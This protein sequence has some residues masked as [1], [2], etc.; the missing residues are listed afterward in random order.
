M[1][2][3]S[4]RIRLLIAWAVFIAIALQIAGFGLHV[5]FERA[6]TRRTQTELEADLRQL[7][8]GMEVGPDGTIRIAREPTD[9]QFDIHFGGRYWQID[10]GGTVLVR[11]R[12]LEGATLPLPAVNGSEPTGPTSKLGGPDGQHLL[13]VIRMHEVAGSDGNAAQKRTL[14]IVTAV[15]A[16]EIEQDTAKFANDL[17]MSLLLL[18]VLLML[19]AWLHVS[20]VLRP[21]EQVRSKVAEVRAGRRNTL[22]G[23][24]PDEVM[25]LVLE[26]NELLASQERAMRVA[27]ERAADLAHG[28]NTPLAIMAAHARTLAR[29]GEP[30]L[31]NEIERQVE[32]MR[33]H[34][35]RELAR[36]R[37]RGKARAGHR[38]S[39]VAELTRQL[40][41]AI[42]SLPR[43]T[44]IVWQHDSPETLHVSI[45]ADD[46]NNILGNLVENAHKWAHTQ[47]AIRI[48]PLDHGV[49]LVIEDDGPG[50]PGDEIDRVLKRGER[51]DVSVGGTG[52]G[53]AIVSDLVELYG[54]SIS[55]GRSALG[56]LRV[57]VD[58]PVE[59]V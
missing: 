33:R 7:R 18:A 11:S 51:A 13:G 41:R 37:A 32:S 43:D 30:D 55:L 54:G 6:I 3:Y 9:P 40:V 52:L 17:F 57:C 58:L 20:Y 45:D 2:T 14:R 44:E 35:E 26:T 59:R 8:R 53:L 31:A 27:R 23:A 1:T 22:E 36:T 34:V 47:I 50:I 29:K 10:E 56:G 15:D 21:F 12:S 46:F 38:R 4:L 5:L 48:E 49:R 24:F 19:G 42:Q 28:L 16:A 39:D 25:P